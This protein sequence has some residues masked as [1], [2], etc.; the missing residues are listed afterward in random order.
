MKLAVYAYNSEPF[1]WYPTPCVSF[2]DF[3]TNQSNGRSIWKRIAI[4]SD[5]WD[6]PINLLPEFDAY[7]WIDSR[8]NELTIDFNEFSSQ[9]ESLDNDKIYGIGKSENGFRTISTGCLAEPN[10]ERNEKLLDFIYAT[11]LPD[12][13][14][15]FPETQLNTFSS[16]LFLRSPAVENVCLDAAKMIKDFPGLNPQVALNWSA[17][18]NTV[19][20][21]NIE[22]LQ[23]QPVR[24]KIWISPYIPP[25]VPRVEAA[26]SISQQPVK[27][28]WQRE[29]PLLESRPSD[30]ERPAIRT[31]DPF[32]QTMD[33]ESKTVDPITSLPL[34]TN[35]IETFGNIDY[36]LLTKM[37]SEG[38]RASI[39]ASFPPVSI[40]MTTWNRTT[41][42]VKCLKALVE[43]IEYPR[44]KLY[45]VL[46]DD[47]SEPGHV[48]ACIDALTSSGISIER[49][50]VTRNYRIGE[51]AKFGHAVNLNNGL[52]EAFRHSDIVLRTEDDLLPSQKIPVFKF[53]KILEN[54]QNVAGIKLGHAADVVRKLPWKGDPENFME[55]ASYWNVFIFNHIAMICHKRVY[56]ILGMYDE[57]LSGAEVE[58]DI[59]KRFMGRFRNR[60]PEQEYN[61]KVL[62]PI[63]PGDDSNKNAIKWFYF[64]HIG[65]DSVSGHH[66]KVNWD[67]EVVKLNSK[68]LAENIRSES[69]KI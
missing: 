12:T 27:V 67:D 31:A 44:H 22:D 30:M 18:K 43:N 32:V 24:H 53:A 33:F 4:E 45:W 39:D 21:E 69:A 47:G 42:A 9:I 40:M 8:V 11:V 23:I 63:M 2:I 5:E 46:A 10:V 36:E 1:V 65:M 16:I 14:K 48:E 20:I 41:L 35:I 13:R 49:V 57:K 26:V 58:K 37:M 38:R 34:K 68:E 15:Y 56:D 28:I 19:K 7:L 59:G 3:S 29:S 60:T 64:T 50:Y 54:N 52:R 51:G 17:W 62:S 55:D 6:S 66:Y 61:M 25:S